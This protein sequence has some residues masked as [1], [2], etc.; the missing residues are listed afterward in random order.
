M[1]DATGRRTRWRDLRRSTRLALLTTAI[2]AVVVSLEVASRLYCWSKMHVSPVATGRLW[3]CY[4]PEFDESGIEQGAPADSDGAYKVLVLGPSVW[5]AGYGDLGARLENEL[6]KEL[7]RPVRL[8]NFAYAGRTSRDAL[9]AYRRLADHHFD[10]VI[11]Y[12][13]INDQVLNNYAREVYQANY[14]HVSRF[15]EIRL[16]ERHPEHPW[17]VFPYILECL[18][19]RMGRVLVPANLTDDLNLGADLKTPPAFRANLDEIVSIA[20]ERGERV[21]LLSF[22]YY[23]PANYTEAAFEAKSLD[24]DIHLSPVNWWGTTASVAMAVDAH[25]AQVEDLAR[26]HPEALFTDMRRLMPDGKAYYHD[27]CHL[28]PGGCVQF[29]DLLMKNTDW[30]SLA[31]AECC[32]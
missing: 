4:F 8:Y 19:S 25:N 28:S 11:V 12:H 20:G 3:N 16:L 2:L 22:A 24:Y 26:C 23:I 1:T 31:R 27:C 13:G 30:H 32:Q 18:G 7:A 10:L 17:V 9:L 21:L 15:E 5:N 6:Q 14:C 29:V